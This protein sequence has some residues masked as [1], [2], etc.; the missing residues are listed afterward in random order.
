MKNQ[1]KI[2]ILRGNSGSGK[3]TIAHLLQEYFKDNTLL[4]SQDVI[5]RQMLKVSDGPNTS[6]INLIID[7][8]K[9]GCKNCQV[10]ILEG[11]LRADWYKNLF[12]AINYLFDNHIYAYYFDL[13][14][15][16]TLIRHQQREEKNE[17]GEDKM[18][19]WYKEK[20]YLDMI[21]ETVITK[22]LSIHQICHLII[23]DIENNKHYGEI[24]NRIE[25]HNIK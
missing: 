22:E 6:A 14:L 11:I 1:S 24:I 19:S 25:N 18:R 13:P 20:D 7:L 3:T 23:S 10:I 12:Y 5:R 17:F 9:F 2:I 4:I 21:S 15:E 16:E 8:V